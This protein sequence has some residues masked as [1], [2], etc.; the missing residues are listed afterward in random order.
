MVFA[1]GL[2]WVNGDG[3][4]A[5]RPGD[6]AADLSSATAGD[7]LRYCPLGRSGDDSPIRRYVEIIRWQRWLGVDAD[8]E[9]W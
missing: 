1:I 9:R 3:K 4:C 6:A 5:I 2:W 7:K 8:I